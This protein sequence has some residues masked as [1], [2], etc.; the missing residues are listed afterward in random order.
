VDAAPVVV[1]LV[2]L[3]VTA[4]LFAVII[5]FIRQAFA[6]RRA[7]LA[8][9]TEDG[10]RRLAEEVADSQRQLAAEMAELRTRVAAIEQLL[11]E[12]G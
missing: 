1:Q 5:V 6:S 2:T 3:T 12:V 10:Y 9:D 11:R 8:A 4:G 7:R